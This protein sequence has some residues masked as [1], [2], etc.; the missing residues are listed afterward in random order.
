MH[1]TIDAQKKFQPFVCLQCMPYRDIIINLT[2]FLGPLWARQ[3]E[4]LGNTGQMISGGRLG[5]VCMLLT[6]ALRSELKASGLYLITS[7]LF[8]A[9][10]R[11]LSQSSL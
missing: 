4:L 9:H 2:S 10:H 7:D 3:M 5:Q 1:I 8:S 11:A 6:P